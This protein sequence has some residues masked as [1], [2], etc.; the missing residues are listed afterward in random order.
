[1]T[2]VQAAEPLDTLNDTLLLRGTRGANNSLLILKL[3]GGPSAPASI[4][5]A[6]GSAQHG[7]LS[8]TGSG[9]RIPQCKTPG[10]ISG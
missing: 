2:D 5:A 4:A 7:Q 9:W 1:V 10:W 3:G 6:G 8:P